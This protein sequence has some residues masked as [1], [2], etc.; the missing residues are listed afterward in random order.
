[1]KREFSTPERVASYNQQR[2]QPTVLPP[3][4]GDDTY[5]DMG[6][7]TVPPSS[8]A[9]A[10]D[11]IL[12]D[13]SEQLETGRKRSLIVLASLVVLIGGATLGSLMWFATPPATTPE[14]A[15]QVAQPTTPAPAPA[16]TPAAPQTVTAPPAPPVLRSVQPEPQPQVAAVPPPAAPA[17]PVAVPPSLPPAAALTPPPVQ[18]VPEVSMGAVSDELIAPQTEGLTPARRVQSVRIVVENDREVTPQR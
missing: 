1:M 2:L 10:S 6:A 3:P 5:S 18:P 9:S 11:D 4:P 17:E 14:P 8:P 7:G 12:P 13:M 16:P 15:P